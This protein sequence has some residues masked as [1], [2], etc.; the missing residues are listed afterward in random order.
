MIY[1][2]HVEDDADIREITK[3][4][5]ELFGDI[6]AIECASGED[7]MSVVQDFVPDLFL[8]DVMMSGMS[9]IDT[10]EKMREISALDKVPVIFMTARAE[11]GEQKELWGLGASDV[12]SKPFDPVTLGQKIKTVVAL[13]V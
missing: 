11:V 12:I 9:G 7:A 5:L 10:L 8:F 3:M 13:A 4:S 2:L 6:L 1:V